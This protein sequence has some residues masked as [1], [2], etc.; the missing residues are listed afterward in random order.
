MTKY[1]RWVTMVALCMSGA[2]IFMLPFLREIY[3]IPMQNA[4]GFTNT[5]MG[6]L[7]SVFGTMSML[8]YFPGGWLAD[9]FS[10]RLLMTWSLF[11]TGLVGFYFSSFPSY[12]MCLLI[13]GFW[14]ATISLVFWSA[15]IKATRNWA[16]HGEQ[17]RA[18][19]FLEGG[20]GI[21]EALTGTI[22]GAVFLWLGS[23]DFALSKVI[24]LFSIA[25]ICLSIFV[26]FTLKESGLGNAQSNEL[27][28]KRVSA[29]EIID[30]LKM[31]EIWLIAIVIMA[32][33]SGYWGTYYF[34]PFATSAFAMSIGVGVA[35]GI[36]KV[37][38]NPIAALTSGFFSDKIGIS[39]AVFG[40]LTFL[41]VTFFIFGKLP[42]GPGMIN[43]MLINVV[44]TAFAVFALRGIYFALLD[45][46][47]IPAHVTGTAAGIVSA[48]GFIP[49]IYM[50]YI[51][52]VLLD[53]FPGSEGYRYFY[54]MISGICFIG[55]LAAFTILRRTKKRQKNR[56]I[57][58]E[59]L[60]EHE[61]A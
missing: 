50:P 59:G 48:I 19:G 2:I 44:L 16:P 10:P 12:F 4:F 42:H 15:M 40:L 3:Y 8:T 61:R 7:M 54:F 58:T 33:Y 13:H 53:T 47:G 24:I 26:W 32:S 57:H 22:F 46:G 17:G 60:A 25:N 30:V 27:K 1:G 41:V 31:P 18:F 43:F 11:L 56:D 28:P 55:A 9:K 5:Q 6:V 36:G 39:R 51:G 45:E 38:L 21:T 49:D 20:R 35:I 37:W 52:G 23:N 29:A 14:G 34:A